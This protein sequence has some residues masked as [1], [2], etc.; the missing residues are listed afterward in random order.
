MT[1]EN[2]TINSVKNQRHQQVHVHRDNEVALRK[3]V[4]DRD[5][6]IKEMEI[7]IKKDTITIDQSNKGS[8]NNLQELINERFDKIEN[9]IESLIENKLAENSNSSS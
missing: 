9:N 1:D 7:Q 5:K 8:E 6:K 2:T 4:E 3:L